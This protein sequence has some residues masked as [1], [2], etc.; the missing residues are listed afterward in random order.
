MEKNMKTNYRIQNACPNC[1]FSIRGFEDEFY[2]NKDK[3]YNSELNRMDDND[4]NL[5]WEWEDSHSVSWCGI[6]IE[7]KAEI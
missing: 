6:C 2:C 7:Y 5:M 1:K 4:I 3:T